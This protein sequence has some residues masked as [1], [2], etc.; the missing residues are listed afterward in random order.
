MRRALIVAAVLAGSIV[1]VSAK[2]EAAYG[3]SNG[4]SRGGFWSR[5]ME[6][7]RAKNDFLLRLIGLR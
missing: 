1:S 5:L 7:E 4:Y 2:S 3:Y 6:I